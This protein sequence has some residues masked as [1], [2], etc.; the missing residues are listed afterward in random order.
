MLYRIERRLQVLKSLQKKIVEI[1]KQKHG[2]F[3]ISELQIGGHCGL[4][5]RWISDEIF[6]KVWAVGICKTCI[7]E[8]KKHIAESS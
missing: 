6:E 5:G 7:N 3:K 2:L 4:C 8:A 1:I